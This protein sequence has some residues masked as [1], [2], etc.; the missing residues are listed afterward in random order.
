MYF[1]HMFVT[2]KLTKWVLT[3]Y[4]SIIILFRRQFVTSFSFHFNETF[5]QCSRRVKRRDLWGGIRRNQL[6]HNM[7]YVQLVSY[8][9]ECW[10]FTKQK[11][12]QRMM[13]EWATPAICQID[14]FTFI[15]LQFWNYLGMEQSYSSIKNN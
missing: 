12:K 8:V 7:V 6:S 15:V 3:I 11:Q 9:V 14:Y 13:K 4:N 5:C 10:L 1:C 2:F